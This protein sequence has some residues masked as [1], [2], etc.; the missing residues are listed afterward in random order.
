[1]PLV[2]TPALIDLAITVGHTMQLADRH[3]PT[4]EWDALTLTLAEERTPT[5]L[6]ELLVA[7][8]ALIARTGHG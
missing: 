7:A 3:A 2:P 1:M 6:A 5:E 8:C 4:T